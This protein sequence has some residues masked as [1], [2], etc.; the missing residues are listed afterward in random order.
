M[1]NDYNVYVTSYNVVVLEPEGRQGRQLIRNNAGLKDPT[2]IY[3]DKFKNSLLVTN[4]H[5]L[6]FLYQMC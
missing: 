1:D 2:E 4:C 3:F 6:G 5:G